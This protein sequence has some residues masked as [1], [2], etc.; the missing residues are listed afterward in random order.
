MTYVSIETGSVKISMANEFPNTRLDITLGSADY[1]EFFTKHFVSLFSIYK[2]REKL[3]FKEYKFFI[4]FLKLKEETSTSEKLFSNIRKGKKVG[5]ARNELAIIEPSLF[6]PKYTRVC[7]KLPRILEENEITS[8]NYLTMN[9]PIYGEGGLI[10]RTYVCDRPGKFI[11]PGVRKNIKEELVNK[12]VFKYIPCCYEKTQFDKKSSAWNEYFNKITIKS[13]KYEHNIYKTKRILPSEGRGT[14]SSRIYPILGETVDRRGVFANPNRF[15]DAVSRAL[16]NKE[17]IEDENKRVKYLK[18]IRKNLIPE[19]CAQENYDFPNY[20]EWFQNCDL[21]FEPRR[22]FRALEYYFKCNIYLFERALDYVESYE[23]GKLEYFNNSEDTIMTIPNAPRG[24]FIDPKTYSK[25]VCV[26]TH[27][28]GAVDDLKI[29]HTEYLEWEIE[30]AKN[31]LEIV[32]RNLLIFSRTDFAPVIKNIAYQY[33][34]NTGRCV[35]VEINDGS[36]INLDKPYLPYPVKIKNIHTVE[37]DDEL[38]NHIEMSRLAR[39]FVEYCAI[40]YVNSSKNSL[41]DF[42]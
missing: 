31:N 13:D 10:P 7:S 22:F 15:I 12:D 42:F 38:K 20:I 28:G 36:V 4:P 25:T 3:L 39:L 16:G 5:F 32:Y 8:A 40:K 37:T 2:S 29:P 41:I 1:V 17:F 33:L 19:I 14:V 26:Y 30:G 24:F 6:V 9:F 18:D 21:Y 11:F 23:N 34:D 27:M 35:K